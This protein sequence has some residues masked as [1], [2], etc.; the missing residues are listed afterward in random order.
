MRL[1]VELP[2]TVAL[3][4]KTA[5]GEVTVTTDAADLDSELDN[6]DLAISRVDGDC[7]R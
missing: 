5:D 1:R 6:A 4:V 2:R 7:G 3:E